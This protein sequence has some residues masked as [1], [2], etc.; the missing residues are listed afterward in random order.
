[1]DTRFYNFSKAVNDLNKAKHNQVRFSKEVTGKGKTQD[2]VQMSGS[3]PGPLQNKRTKLAPAVSFVREA[4]LGQAKGKKIN[5]ASDAPKRKKKDIQLKRT[6]P[7]VFTDRVERPPDGL[8]QTKNVQTLR[9]WKRS[10]ETPITMS[11]PPIRLPGQKL[12]PMN[13][14]ET[15]DSWRKLMSNN[16]AR[17]AGI[18]SAAGAS[19]PGAAAALVAAPGIVVPGPGPVPASGS[20]SPVATSP[21]PVLRSTRR[22]LVVSPGP[23]SVQDPAQAF[24]SL[25]AEKKKKKATPRRKQGNK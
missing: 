8:F 16:G 19:A 1:M 18:G 21:P 15:Q 24:P 5:A 10:G 23:V 17:T 9:P 13:K 12:F 11:V 2:L 6:F 3:R 7:K 25:S 22:P 14:M 4:P 20:S